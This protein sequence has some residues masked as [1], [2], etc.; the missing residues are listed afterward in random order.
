MPR[1]PPCR[2][3]P[4]AEFDLL[5]HSVHARTMGLSVCL[6][7]ARAL[8]CSP[9]HSA[10]RSH[11]SERRVGCKD[12]YLCHTLAQSSASWARRTRRDHTGTARGRGAMW[13]HCNV[14]SSLRIHR[15]TFLWQRSV[16]YDSIA[17]SRS[18][19][20]RRFPSITHADAAPGCRDWST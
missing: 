18:T 5:Q 2:L 3:V 17:Q 15:Y 12:K 8:R 19:E 4:S 20:Q 6:V 16:F 1:L 10:A 9:I 13:G 7:L 11:V 14:F